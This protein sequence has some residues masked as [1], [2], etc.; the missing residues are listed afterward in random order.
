MTLV[1]FL[2]IKTKKLTPIFKDLIKE[3]IWFIESG[4]NIRKRT[5]IESSRL[6]EERREWR[7]IQSHLDDV[8]EDLI[9]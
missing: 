1:K 4:Y 5:T 7:K 2:S 3:F 8:R 9:K 6:Y